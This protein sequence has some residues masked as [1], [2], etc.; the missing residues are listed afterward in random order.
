MLLLEYVRPL[1]VNGPGPLTQQEQCV[2]LN[3]MKNTTQAVYVETSLLKGV[4]PRPVPQDLQP[5]SLIFS[6]KSETRLQ[7]M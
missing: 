4:K 6:S 1:P 3:N 7:S 5:S 2:R